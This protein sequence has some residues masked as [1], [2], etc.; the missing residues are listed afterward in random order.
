MKPGCPGPHSNV[1]PGFIIPSIYAYK[2][3]RNLFRWNME[4]W[5]QN[6]RGYTDI[7]YSVAWWWWCTSDSDLDGSRIE[8]VLA[9]P[10]DRDAYQYIKSAKAATQVSLTHLPIYSLFSLTIQR[11]WMW[12]P[13]DYSMHYPARCPCSLNWAAAGQQPMTSYVVIAGNKFSICC[14]L[15]TS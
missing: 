9:K 12:P 15:I 11:V 3:L 10:V 2:R 1:G 5:P 8:V 4:N 6:V 14:L 13:G 7:F